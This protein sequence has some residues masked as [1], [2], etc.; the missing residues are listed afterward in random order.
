MGIM[1]KRIYL[2]SPHMGGQ[3]LAYVQDAFH[4]NWV[5]PKGP[6]IP[7]FENLLKAY[8]GAS[9]A[10]AVVSGTAAIHLALRL[11]GVE[12]GDEVLCSTFTFVA[13]INPVVYQNATPILVES[14]EDTWNMCPI[15]LEEAIIDRLKKGKRPKAIIV[16]H[17]YGM[18]AK[19]DAIMEIAE[20]YA[21]PVIE[22]AAE[23]LGSTYHGQH[24]GTIG[25]LGIYSFNGN[26]IITT[27][28]G[29]ALVSNSRNHI[30]RAH[31]L[32]TQ[33]KD[34]EP[35]Y[36]HPEV[37]YNYRMSNIA[38]GIGCG[39]M[40]VLADRVIKRR[41]NFD[42]Y[43]HHLSNY[44]EVHFL[45]EPQGALSNRWLSTIILGKEMGIGAAEEL[46]KYLEGKNIESRPLWKPMHLQPIYKHAPYY[47][48][49]TS[50]DL[51]LHGLCLPSGSNL[52]EFDLDFVV[53]HIRHFLE[54]SV[55]GKRAV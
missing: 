55:T 11:L 27:S 51:F 13:T 24:C 33:A 45:H 41:E 18:P 29:G 49:G 23:A 34:D 47:G 20:R 10:V 25:D 8:T 14:E 39:Q 52:S 35:Y 28:G 21:I 42:Y 53:K 48:D 22:D 30:A 1:S 26:K 32:A 12:Q 17:L 2:S 54:K 15:A 19:M 37:G 16:V 4:T 46:R 3:E 38:A 31:F 40:E 50:E 6:N 7:H 43:F 36:Q 9:S 44:R 5:A